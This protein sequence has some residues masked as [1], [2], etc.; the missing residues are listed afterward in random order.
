LDTET[1]PAQVTAKR[2]RE[3]AAALDR[4]MKAPSPHIR[5]AAVIALGKLGGPDLVAVLA[6]MLDDD[7]KL[8]RE[9][10]SLGLG[11]LG[12]GEA[13]P[14][15]SGRLGDPAS[16]VATGRGALQRAF[17]AVGL[18][19]LARRT[20]LGVGTLERLRSLSGAGQD[21]DVELRLASILAL[22]LAADRNSVPS[23]TRI[24]KEPAEDE[25]VRAFAASSLARVGEESTI[26]ALVAALEDGSS[27]VASSAATA[28]AAFGRRAGRPAL[29]GL[30]KG[31]RSHPQ[32]AAKDACILALGEAGGVGARDIL[33]ALLGNGEQQDVT[34]AALALGL[35]GRAY[36]DEAMDVGANLIRRFLASRNHPERGA[37]AIGIGLLG[38]RDAGDVLADALRGT[39]SPELA[40]YL[41]TAL[42]MLQ[43]RGA[44]PLLVDVIRNGKNEGARRHAAVALGLIR[45][46]DASPVLLDMIASATESV[47]VQGAAMM[48]LSY[49]GDVRAVPALIRVLEDTRRP[50][51]VRTWAA[52]AL[53]FLGDNDDIP[54]LAAIRDHL[55][56]LVKTELTSEL[57]QVL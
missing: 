14:I 2:R 57:L 48:G 33:C 35:Y 26:P 55:N 39:R 20:D 44:E 5:A 41:A 29:R 12:V 45:D 13:E 51:A 23:L 22:G 52:A 19:L 53:G 43:A 17:A 9:R 49:M 50:A 42:G 3:I 34:F 21:Q 24:L 32:R 56:H 16:A 31:A 15:R 28:L 10:A 27:L 47:P 36:P 38:R 11:I 6:R 25:R 37:I 18:G 7:E 46:P 4:T 30:E 40:G 8:V 54:L 1:I